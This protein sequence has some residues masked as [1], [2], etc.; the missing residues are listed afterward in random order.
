M[1]NLS[2]AVQSVID[3]GSGENS[4]VIKSLNALKNEDYNNWCSAVE[5]PG[6]C[7]RWAGLFAKP[8]CAFAWVFLR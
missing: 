4:A 8:L 7:F 2:S 6:G 1:R 5:A 3:H